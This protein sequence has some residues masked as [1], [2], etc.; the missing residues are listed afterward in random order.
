MIMVLITGGG[1]GG[2]GDFVRATL[3]SSTEKMGVRIAIAISACTISP[4][5]GLLE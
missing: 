1:G 5:V 3:L 4:T 2:A